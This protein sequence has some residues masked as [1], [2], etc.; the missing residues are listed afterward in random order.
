M[1]FKRLMLEELD[2]LFGREKAS[3]IVVT[4]FEN[5]YHRVETS[6]YDYFGAYAEVVCEEK[7]INACQACWEYIKEAFDGNEQAAWDYFSKANN[8]D[9]LLIIITYMVGDDSEAVHNF[10]RRHMSEVQIAKFLENGN[11]V[12]GIEYKPID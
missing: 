12:A 9:Y 6:S 11:F 10:L 3:S 1:N 4:A 8:D 7:D 2:R 5:A